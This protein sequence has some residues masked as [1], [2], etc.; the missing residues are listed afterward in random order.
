MPA[1]LD[2]TSYGDWIQGTEEDVY[3]LSISEKIDFYPVSTIVNNPSNNVKDCCL[4][5]ISG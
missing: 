1:I 5:L 4:P 3:D 2:K